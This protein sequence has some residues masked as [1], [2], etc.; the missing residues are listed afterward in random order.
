MLGCLDNSM[1]GKVSHGV[2]SVSEE[3]RKVISALYRVLRSL[4]KALAQIRGRGLREIQTDV[5][6]LSDETSRPAI[7]IVLAHGP[8][9][10]LHA[11]L[12]FLWLHFKGGANRLCSL[13]DVIWVD[14][15]RVAQFTHRPASARGG[16]DPM[17]CGQNQRMR[18]G[19]RRREADGR[20]ER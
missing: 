8:S 4:R 7:Y 12:F 3:F 2:P 13:I 19:N 6:K 11:L 5:T 10:A 16:R 20:H 14:L 1:A 18:V 15:Q 9:H 17:G